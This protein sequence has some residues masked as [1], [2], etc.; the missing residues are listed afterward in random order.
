MSIMSTHNLRVLDLTTR[1]GVALTFAFGLTGCTATSGLR[2]AGSQPSNAKTFLAVGDKPLPVVGGEPG[3]S[4]AAAEPN[5]PTTP[6]KQ[7]RE[8]GRISGRV[9]DADGRPVAEAKVRLAVSGAAGGKVVRASTDRSGAF[10]LHGLRPN[11]DYTVIAEW[12]GE[13]GMQTGRAEAQASDTDIKISLVGDDTAPVRAGTNAKVGR[14]SDREAL[15]DMDPNGP[16]EEPRSKGSKSRVNEEDLPP[17]AEADQADGAEAETAMAPTKSRG[18]SP[19]SWRSGGRAGQ[20]AGE[21]SDSQTTA[22]GAEHEDDVPNPL[23]PAREPGSEQS[24]RPISRRPSRTIVPESDDADPFGP[25]VPRLAAGAA[26]AESS[27]SPRSEFDSPSRPTREARNSPAR[28]AAPGALV[29]TPEAYGPIVVHDA[30]PF[31]D[32]NPAIAAADRADGPPARPARGARSSVSNRRQSPSQSR[33]ARSE[34][35]QATWGDITSSADEMP[36]LE[37]EAAIAASRAKTDPGVTRRSLIT[38]G[39]EVAGNKATQAV[40]TDPLKV[41]CEYDDRHRKIVDFQLPALDG[42]PIRFQQID[43]DFVLLD[44]WGTWCQP[45]LKS[46]PH[47][48][49]LQEKMGTRLAVLGIACEPDEFRKANPR[50]AQMAGKLKVNYPILL[51][52][53]DGSCALQEALKV[54]SFPTMVLVDREGRVLWRGQDST[55]ATLARLD[56]VLATSESATATR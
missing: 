29:M 48:V 12:D 55:P 26:A 50:V 38:T 41:T 46:I 36:P 3:S 54:Q 35:P 16:E 23:P 15:D 52:R 17:A 31:G 24:A 22:A 32:N 37:G 5:E 7:S 6:R 19:A 8:E 10:T 2:T 4:V 27:S 44:F 13:D 40:L 39:A 49:E 51:T 47:L 30:D 45:C 21:S 14:V 34:K 28:D 1:L 18:T 9:F 56:R 43:A 53:N 25:S 42:K 11:T 33:P 20:E